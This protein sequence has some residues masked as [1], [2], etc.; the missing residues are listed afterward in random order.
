MLTVDN[1]AR[2]RRAHRD[3]MKIREMA[4]RF[5]HSRRKIREALG[6]PEP[7][8]YTRRQEPPAPKLDRFKPLIEEILAADEEAPPKQRHQ[9]TQIFRRLVKE[10]YQGGYDQVRRYVGKRRRREQETFIPLD[11]DPGQR[12]EADFGHIWVDFPEGRR[13]VHVLLLTWAFS[14]CPF[15]MALPPGPPSAVLHGR[16]LGQPPRRSPE[17]V[18]TGSLPPATGQDRSA[19]L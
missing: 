18:S 12:V 13:Q 19:D 11:H 3:G 1:Y 7:R 5:R 16:G 9:A 15:A 2:I 17:A 6:Q 8:P 4:R 10:G 14:Y